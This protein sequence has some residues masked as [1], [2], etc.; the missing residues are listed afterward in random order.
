[1]ASLYMWKANAATVCR[2]HRTPSD[3][4]YEPLTPIETR[5]FVRMLRNE[6][7]ARMSPCEPCEMGYGAR[8]PEGP[9]TFA[10][11]VLTA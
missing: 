5:E 7:L 9:L 10:E 2:F 3:W 11:A 8:R 1:M 6:A 4:D